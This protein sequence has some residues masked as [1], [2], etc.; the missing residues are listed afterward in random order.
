MKFTY[1]LQ[2]G[3]LKCLFSQTNSDEFTWTGVLRKI[4]RSNIKQHHD[5]EVMFA[6]DPT[7]GTDNTPATNASPYFR[8]LSDERLYM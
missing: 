2:S 1:L 5:R 7:S 8:N 3:N 6:I 4:L